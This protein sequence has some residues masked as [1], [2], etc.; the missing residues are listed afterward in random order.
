MTLFVL[1]YNNYYNRQVKIEDNLNDY[2]AASAYATSIDDVNFNPN[3]GVNTTQVLNSL[4]LDLTNVDYA[5]LYDALSDTI[6][7]KWFILEADRTRS[8]QYLLKLYRDLVGDYYNVVVNAPAFIEKATL[9]AGNSLIYN[10]EN[11]TYNQIKSAEYVLKDSTR[12]PWLVGYLARDRASNIVATVPTNDVKVDYLLSSFGDYAYNTYATENFRGHIRDT[13]YQVQVRSY[14]TG[15]SDRWNFC[16]G[17]EG[18]RK[19]PL[20]YS[21]S[22]TSTGVNAYTSTNTANYYRQ[23]ATSYQMTPSAIMQNLETAARAASSDWSSFSIDTIAQTKTTSETQAFLAEEGKIIQI[24]DKFYQI[25]IE[26]TNTDASN[27]IRSTVPY[28]SSLGIKFQAVMGAYNYW[29]STSQTAFILEGRSDFY[30]VYYDELDV[31]TYTLTIKPGTNHL[32]DAPYDMF[33]LPYPPANGIF[34]YRTADG[35]KRVKPAVV[36]NIIQQLQVAAQ[37]NLFD[38]QLV[39]YCPVANYIAPSSTYYNYLDLSEAV[40]DKEYQEIEGGAGVLVWCTQSSFSVNVDPYTD[41]YTSTSIPQPSTDPVEFKVEHECDFYRMVSPNYN[42]TFEIKSTSNQGL[43]QFKATCSYKPYM[44]Y[45]QVAPSFAGLYGSNFGDARG[46]ICGG[47]FSLSAVSD[48]WQSYQINNKNYQ[49]IFDRQIDNLEFNNNI[50]MFQAKLNATVGAISGAV[51]GASTGAQLGGGWGAAAG[52]VVGGVASGVGGALDIEILKRQQS[53]TL[54]YTN[55]MY[56]YNLGNIQARPQ[57]LTK[58]SSFN[59]HNKI[60]PILEY[61]TASDVEKEALRNKL[62][63]NGMTV[64]TIGTIA[65]YQLNEP[66]Y[67]KAKLIRLNNTDIGFH[68]LAV[69]SEEL[70]KGVFV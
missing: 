62:K 51:S 4:D 21:G 53:E 40:E 38:L 68:E 60:F 11:M 12:V 44:P 67:I 8:G 22:L 43:Q 65:D 39:P 52:A 32:S 49:N 31:D 41:F 24:A 33:A 46:L 10:N 69:L 23:N 2:L 56:G 66:S 5:I 55:D 13:V 7:S 19:N 15:S 25:R 27:I 45:I 59:P 70:N 34:Y 16:W 20:S 61:Y 54:D 3:D 30:K 29:E 18:A 48:L 37:Q 6:V 47:D 28:N 57:S 1:R 17:Y 50:G 42:G 64:M 35:Y 14:A 63:Y 36:L 58:V 26:Q 9:P